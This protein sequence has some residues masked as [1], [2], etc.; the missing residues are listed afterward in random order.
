MYPVG[1]DPLDSPLL[2]GVGDI[3]DES[4]CRADPESGRLEGSALNV[5]DRR[6]RLWSIH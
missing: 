4:V 2:R 5:E 6:L 1:K 3:S